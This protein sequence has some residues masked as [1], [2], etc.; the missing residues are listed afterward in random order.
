M[1]LPGNCLLHNDGY[2]RAFLTDFHLKVSLKNCL[3]RK[4]CWRAPLIDSQ[5]ELLLGSRLVYMDGSLET[6]YN[7]LL[8]R[9]FDRDFFLGI[10]MAHW[11]CSFSGLLTHV[12]VGN[13]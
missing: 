8:A 10:R 7:G 1:V 11:K 5:L 6:F 4:A 12:L 9:G 2:W 13:L 3:M